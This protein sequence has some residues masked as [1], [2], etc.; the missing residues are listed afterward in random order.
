MRNACRF[1]DDGSVSILLNKRGGGTF[2]AIVTRE[3][4]EKYAEPFEGTWTAYKHPRTGKYYARGTY[5]NTATGE[6]KQPM[7]HRLIMNPTKGDITAHLNKDTLDCRPE[8]MR[9]VPIGTDIDKLIESETQL[10][11]PVIIEVEAVVEVPEVTPVKGVSFHKGKGKW[12]TS[13]YHEK[14]RYRL[15]YWP[16]DKLEEANAAVTE[17]R[18][19]GPE[20]YFKRHPKKGRNK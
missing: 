13:A 3:H 16:P 7:L 2:E 20:E 5:K 10:E 4:Y 1:N 6:Y 19:I 9:N 14:V 11:P 8:N 18:E 15:G 17:F 12:E